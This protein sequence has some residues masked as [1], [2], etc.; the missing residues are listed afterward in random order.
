M[1]QFKR[2]KMFKDDFHELDESKEIVTNLVEEYE[3]ATKPDYIQ[4]F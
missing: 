3:A 1:D 2:E 4:R